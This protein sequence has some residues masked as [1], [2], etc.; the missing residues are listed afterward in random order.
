MQ[1]QIWEQVTNGR[2][3]GGSG[4]VG[5]DGGLRGPF[6]ALL[7]APTVGLS[8]ASLGEA[9]RYDTSLAPRLLELATITVGAHWRANFEWAAHARLALEAG[10][11]AEVIEAVGDR[12]DPVFERPDEAA[13][14]RFTAELLDT[15]RVA[16]ATYDEI[17]GVVGEQ[18]VVEL[19]LLAGYYCAICFAL[20][21]FEVGPPDGVEPRWPA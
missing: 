4:F 6:N 9:L 19:V 15:G 17:I 21:T 10:V 12:R 11:A 7:H 2:R 13:V 5:A 18:G 14:H 3:V 1:Q 20:N 16:Q 8:A